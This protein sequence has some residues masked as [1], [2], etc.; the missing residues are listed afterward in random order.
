MVVLWVVYYFLH[1]LLAA[2][3][4]KAF[5]SR[6]MGRTYRHYRLLYSLFQLLGLI[7]ILLYQY[8]FPSAKL[9][10]PRPLIWL[11][12]GLL[13]IP[14]GVIMTISLKKY[15]FLLS[16][17]RSLYTPA[18]ASELKVNGLHRLV[19]HPLYLGTILFVWGLFLLWP[20]LTN[21][22]TVVLLT[23]YVR[24]GLIF[25]EQKLLKEFGA[26]YQQF[27]ERVPMLVPSFKRWNQ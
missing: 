26:Q 6:R 13:I 20:T 12:A 21:L 4:V 27:R 14:G 17:V 16:G 23:A 19:R 15:F 5:F 1:S 10:G 8:S 25:E 2:G 3:S 9:F 11:A 24:I 18:P 7:A 22:I